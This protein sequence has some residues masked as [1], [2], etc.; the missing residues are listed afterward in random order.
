L[1]PH[2]KRRGAFASGWVGGTRIRRVL[3]VRA[4]PRRRAI[5]GAAG[6]AES[7]E[8]VVGW[9]ESIRVRSA[10]VPSDRLGLALAAVGLFPVA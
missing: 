6:V 7:D 10:L 1:E 9:G 4:R 8:G 3:G 2:A 5:K